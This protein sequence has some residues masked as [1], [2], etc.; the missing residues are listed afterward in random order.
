MNAKTDFALHQ[1]SAL[2]STDPKTAFTLVL[3][4]G[5][6]LDSA[7]RRVGNDL[8][9]KAGFDGNG[10][11]RSIGYA[12]NVAFGKLEKIGIEQGEVMNAHLF[13]EPSGSRPLDIA[14]SNP[15]DPFSPT[16]ISNSVLHFSW[17][18]LRDGVYEVVAYLS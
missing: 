18:E 14:F 11:F 1:A 17:T 7:T 8:L 4:A 6:R 15:E 2:A 5:Q 9:R 3:A 12:L 10:R 13:R 16:D